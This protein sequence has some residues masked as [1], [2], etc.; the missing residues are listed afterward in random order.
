MHSREAEAGAFHL[1]ANNGA[2]I[3]GGRPGVRKG[4]PLS[5]VRCHL[6]R[7]DTVSTYRVRIHASEFEVEAG[8][9]IRAAS[10]LAAS[11]RIA[12]GEILRVKLDDADVVRCYRVLESF[13]VVPVTC[14]DSGT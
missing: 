5:H 3:V 9:P 14:E 1:S 2:V 10:N 11:E 8:R 4:P 6:R 12:P 7:A 13:G